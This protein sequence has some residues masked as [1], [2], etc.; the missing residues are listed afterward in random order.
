MA[1]LSTRASLEHAHILKKNMSTIAR[2]GVVAKF[3]FQL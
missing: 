2:M 1:Y 3:V